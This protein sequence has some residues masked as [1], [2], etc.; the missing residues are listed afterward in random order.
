MEPVVETEA[1]P[2]ESGAEPT[3]PTEPQAPDAP[4]VQEPTYITTDTMNEALQKQDASFKSWM[5]R[6]D[7]ETM[8]HIGNVINERMNQRPPETPDELSTRLLENPRDIIRSEMDVYNQERTSN[9]TTHL[10]STMENVGMLMES[11]PLYTDKELG[12]DVIGEIK[13]LVQ[14]TKVDSKI[15]PAQASKLML[16]DA[17]SNVIR[18]RQGIKTNPLEN[19]KP[20]N[21]GTNLGAPSRTTAKA[22]VPKLDTVTQNMA[23]KWGYS[24]ED[25]AKLYGD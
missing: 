9:E 24:P 6:R 25:L 7:K 10:N 1:T 20:G 13:T 12:N 2:A 4:E 22:K 5:G 19:N 18:K 11:D 17:L 3:E 21:S 16:A 23:D 8:S 15:P 14:T